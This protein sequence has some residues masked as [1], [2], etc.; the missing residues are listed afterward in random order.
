V[1]DAQRA[2]IPPHY[3]PPLPP[4]LNPLNLRHYGLLLL[5]IYFQPSKLK[6]YLW[7][8]DPVLYFEKGRASLW[9]GLRLPAYRNLVL[10]ALVLTV[11]LSVAV[12]ALASWAQRTEL[13]WLFMVFGVAVGVTLGLAV[14]VGYSM[15]FGVAAGVVAGVGYSLVF[16]VAVSVVAGVASGLTGDVVGG[17]AGGMA[18]GV[19]FGVIRGV[20]GGVIGGLAFG[21]TFGATFSTVFS[22]VLGLVFGLALGAAGGLAGGLRGIFYVAQWPWIVI[23]THR[24]RSDPEWTG[25]M[26]HSMY[27]DELMVLPALGGDYIVAQMLTKDFAQSLI[28]LAQIIGNPFQRWAICNGLQ[29]VLFADSG[30][31][32]VSL[33][34][35]IAR[36]SSL[37]HCTTFPYTE[38]DLSRLPL[39]RTLVFALLAHKFED[40]TGGISANSERLVWRLTQPLRQ[41]RTQPYTAF[42][43]WLCELTRAEG[44]HTNETNYEAILDQHFDQVNQALRQIEPLQHGPEIATSWR[45][46][47]S[48]SQ[49]KTTEGL[50][51]ATAEL[52][53]LAPIRDATTP[54][55]LP[56]VIAALTALGDVSNQVASAQAA[57]NY[58]WQSA[59]LNRAVGQ[60][61]ELGNYIE[62]NV[63]QPERP[64]LRVVVQRWQKL[65]AVEQGKLGAAA[66]RE[67]SPAERLLEGV[68]EPRADIWRKPATPIPN[69][70]VVGDPVRPPL[71]TG[72]NDIFNQIDGI[73]RA[74]PD[75]DS[76]I[77]YGH[78]R[79]GKSSILRNLN[80]A[81]P[82][83]II[84]YADMMGE[85]AFVESTAGLLLT[86]A[87]KIYNAVRRAVPDAGLIQPDENEFDTAANAQQHFNRFAARVREAIGGRKLI[88]VLDEFEG[89]QDAVVR[90]KVGPEIY[91]FLR[92][93]TQ[94]DWITLVMGGLHQLE[95]M[96]HDYAQPFFGS[97]RN[98]TVSYLSPDE[99]R[100]LVTNPSPDFKLDYERAA[101][102]RIISETGGQPYLIQLICS[103]AVDQL[104][105]ELFD[106]NQDRDL[107]INLRNIEAVLG[108]D[109]FQRGAVYFDGVWTQTHDKP[110]VQPL[111]RALAQRD[112]PW[113]EADLQAAGLLDADAL[114]WAEQH[115]VLRRVDGVDGAWA[116]CV[117]LMR[118]FVRAK[119]VQADAAV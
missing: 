51:Q 114:V 72:R 46:I 110:A 108:D 87:D 22:P 41:R 112:E 38:Q 19:A 54:P 53:R 66:L 18:G 31:R 50:A 81:A 91:R 65:I 80:L 78:R 27:W 48:Y 79:M 6:R 73:W 43:H 111:L 30:A 84:A 11:V 101:V 103:A 85:T 26:R 71:F 74:K 69:P 25:W 52:A 70:Y 82:H 29:R 113:R 8:V 94:E 62:A 88:L 17:V 7:Q 33:L 3:G 9:R 100:R 2:R 109:F 42:C 10:M 67:M 107:R 39:A 118:R 86:L 60:L 93:L 40:S 63:L 4:V 90:G 115:D 83:A 49:I 45:I 106:L 77:L 23:T 105:H 99:A 15:V 20:A 12:T 59:A 24:A 47:F 117:P 119:L 21:A 92:T 58:G 36:N 44:D 98:I 28:G 61:T 34:Y 76:I 13:R 102:E 56:N 95:E 64:L 97:Y 35:Q 55:L 75:P 14:G 37:C 16:G 32:H 57:T 96:S 89:I 5:W 68:A 1:T 104:N 116:F